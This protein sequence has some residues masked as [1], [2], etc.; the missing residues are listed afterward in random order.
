LGAGEIEKVRISHFIIA[1]IA[2]IWFVGKNAIASESTNWLMN[3]PVSMMDWGNE[4]AEKSAQKAVDHLN[5]LMEQ[6]EKQDYKL[7]DDDSMPE[8]VKKKILENRKQLVGFPT[9]YGYRY[10]PAYAGYDLRH[11]RIMV[12]AFVVPQYALHTG[13]IDAESCVAIVEDFQKN[14]LAVSG[15]SSPQQLASELWFSHNG[16]RPSA[17]PPNF[18]NDLTDHIT[19]VIHLDMYPTVDSAFSCEKPLIGG[20]VTSVV[21]KQNRN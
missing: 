9:R 10:G 8:E 17:M 5:Q 7:E 13:T 18:V 15:A 12:G 11:D 6:R 16:Y 14:L 4:R 3:N 21:K 2:G 1:A 19:V 20:S